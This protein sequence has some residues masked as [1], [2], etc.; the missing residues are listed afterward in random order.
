MEYS[1]VAN[2]V[3]VNCVVADYPLDKNWY[4]GNYRIGTLFDGVT[5]MQK[6]VSPVPPHRRGEILTLL[7]SIDAQTAKPRTMREMLLGNTST[8]AFVAALD[9]QAATLRTELAKLP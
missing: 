5:F 9:A 3:V 8:I 4:E 6:P 7:A 2:G 1:I